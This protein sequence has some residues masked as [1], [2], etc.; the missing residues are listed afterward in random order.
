MKRGFLLLPLMIVGA[1][2]FSQDQYGLASAHFASEKSI[3]A[4]NYAGMYTV[5]EPLN[6][7]YDALP[8]KEKPMLQKN[9]KSKIVYMPFAKKTMG[10]FAAASV[11]IKNSPNIE[12]V[13]M[14]PITE[15][16]L[17]D[18]NMVRNGDCCSV[19]YRL[20]NNGSKYKYNVH[21]EGIVKD[22]ME[23]SPIAHAYIS[24]NSATDPNNFIIVP[25]NNNGTF[26]AD[27]T[28]D[29]IIGITIFKKGYEEREIGFS[30]G[31]ASLRNFRSLHSF[32]VCLHKSKELELP[33]KEAKAVNKATP[34]NKV[35][36]YKEA[37]SVVRF[38][39]NSKALDKDATKL[40]DSLISVIK[41]KAI[42]NPT[43][44]LNGYTDGRGNAA[45]NVYL[46]K[47][48]SLAC[49]KY[50]KAH[51][52]SHVTMRLNGHGSTKPLVEEKING[53]LDDAKARA[54]N[55]RV[56]LIV[57]FGVEQVKGSSYLLMKKKKKV[58][59]YY[60]PHRDKASLC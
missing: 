16:D 56:E 8:L 25:T 34:V 5:N 6:N 39:Y 59:G 22:C 21:V 7:D 18:S 41:E 52:L 1:I 38:G 17:D 9:K 44:E 37:S 3:R 53:N 46:S 50:L 55:R 30:E 23:K 4:F 36:N 51:G 58:Q 49:K 42:V 13:K 28:D 48:R 32:D 33:V 60:P 12:Y 57:R 45:Y 19:R 35:F 15:A 2:S 54:L 29:S 40:L 24:I 47:E 20:A 43:I 11:S 27:V 10:N 14:N 26:S 31:G